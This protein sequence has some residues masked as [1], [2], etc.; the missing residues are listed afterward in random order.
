MA[1][2]EVAI[3]GVDIGFEKG[4]ATLLTGAG[5]F[6]GVVPGTPFVELVGREFGVE[7]VAMGGVVLAGVVDTKAD[8]VTDSDFGRTVAGGVIV[9][10]VVVSMV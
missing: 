8:A 9:E 5:V 7:S 3:P 4:L 1:Y 2:I 6:N 10:G